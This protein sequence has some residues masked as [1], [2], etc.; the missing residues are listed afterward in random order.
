MS[1]PTMVSIDRWCL[2]AR[3]RLVYST[4][5]VVVDLVELARL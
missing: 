1:Q 4:S 5:S 3:G 2:Y